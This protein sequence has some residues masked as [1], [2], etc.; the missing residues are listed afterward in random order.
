VPQSLPG[1]PNDP[2]YR[3]Q[4]VKELSN[5][6][7]ADNCRI[8]DAAARYIDAD[9]LAVPRN[10]MERQ[11]ALIRQMRRTRLAREVQRHD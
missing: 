7:E 5:R 6:E 11:T 4:E 8:L 9:Q 10:Q 3:A 1:N 2:T